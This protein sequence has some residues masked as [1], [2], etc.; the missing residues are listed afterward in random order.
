MK[1]DCA[2]GWIMF[3][4]LKGAKVSLIRYSNSEGDLGRWNA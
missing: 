1:G 4:V 2:K 3:S